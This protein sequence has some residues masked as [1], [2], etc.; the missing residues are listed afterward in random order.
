MQMLNLLAGAKHEI[1]GL[2]RRVEIRDVQNDTLRHLL[3]DAIG[4]RY[5]STGGQALAPDI[6]PQLN[7]A[8]LELTLPKDKNPVLKPEAAREDDRST[9]LTETTPTPPP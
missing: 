1:V 2:R 5:E 3:L 6:V 8:I 7:E 9:T 4:G